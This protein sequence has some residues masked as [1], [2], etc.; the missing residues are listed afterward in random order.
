MNSIHLVNCFSG[1]RKV[2]GT[3]RGVNKHEYIE[4]NIMDRM[5]RRGTN[6]THGCTSEYWVDAC[7]HFSVF[8]IIFGVNII[9]YDAETCKTNSVT[10]RQVR[11][12]RSTVPSSSAANILVK[13]RNGF[14]S[15]KKMYGDSGWDKS[16]CVLFYASHY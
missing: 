9:W 3:L 11:K 5:Y 14:I 16:V 7:L 1:K 10:K 13:C 8:A 4:D 6:Y 2:D 15:P 12:S